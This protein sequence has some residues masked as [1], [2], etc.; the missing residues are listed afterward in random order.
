MV[1]IYL[2]LFLSSLCTFIKYNKQFEKQLQAVMKFWIIE[3]EHNFNVHVFNTFFF[4]D[5]NR[6]KIYIKLMFYSESQFTHFTAAA[7]AASYMPIII[8]RK[9]Y[10]FSP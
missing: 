10:S 2:L 6:T 5:R 9:L 1:G 7:V 3:P 4:I 8:E